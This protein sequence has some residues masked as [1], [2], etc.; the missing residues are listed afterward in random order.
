MDIV[1]HT[2]HVMNSRTGSTCTVHILHAKINNVEERTR[3]MIDTISSTSWINQLSV[4]DQ[5][6]YAARAERTIEKLVNEIFMKVSSSVSTEF[7]EYMVSMT[8]QDVLEEHASHTAIPL[9]ELFKEK[10]S[11]NPGFDFHTETPTSFIAFGEAKYSGRTTP[12]EKALV[13]IKDFI[14]LKKDIAEL[15]DL[16]RFCSEQAANNVLNDQKAFVAAFSL[17]VKKPS[18]MF[19]KILA[20]SEIIPL[21]EYPE[22]YLIGV[23]VSDSKN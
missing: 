19:S 8:A 21:F 17:N 2:Q 10:L 18:A 13:Q 22:L 3:E 5:A 15:A 16:K 6:S 4:V 1:S 23:E 9:A 14:V 20:G 7:G 12:Y 11:G